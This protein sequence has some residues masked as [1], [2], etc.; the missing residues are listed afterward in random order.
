M[1]ELANFHFIRPLCLVLIPISLVVWWLLRQQNDPLRSWRGVVDPK[2]LDALSVHPEGRQRWRDLPRLILWLLAAFAIAGPSWRAEPSP[3][4]DDPVPVLLLLKANDTMEQ[5]DL[6]PTRM[7]RARLK[8]VDLAEQR[9]GQPTGLIAYAGTAHLVLPPT[10]DTD[11]VATMA[12]EISPDIMPRQGDDL[13]AALNL[14]AKTFGETRGSIVV[15]TDTVAAGGETRLTEFRTQY[16]TNVYFLGVARAGTPEETDLKKAAS[17]VNAEFTLLTPDAADVEKI[18]RRV[19]D[20]P[21]AVTGTGEGIRWAEAGWSLVPVVAL[22][23]L[24]GFRR[25]E[26]AQQITEEPAA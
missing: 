10:R 23:A 8:I 15:V 3:F 6:M 5:S 19:A 1:S 4:A 26:P 12:A 14:A 21:V 17:V 11:I 2:L 13:A 18:A 25:E 9:K 16:K 24:A 22:F 20:T 7:E